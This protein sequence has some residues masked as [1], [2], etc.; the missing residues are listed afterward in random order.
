MANKIEIDFDELMD[1][2][3]RARNLTPY[4]GD[5]DYNYF[6]RKISKFKKINDVN[7]SG[8]DE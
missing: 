2:L 5:S 7:V 3:I 6:T 8:G 1:V 4:S